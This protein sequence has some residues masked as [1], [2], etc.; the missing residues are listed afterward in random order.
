MF[1]PFM[2]CLDNVKFC[3][4]KDLIVAKDSV[5]SGYP[6][7]VQR[8]SLLVW[9]QFKIY[10]F[11]WS[12]YLALSD[13]GLPTGWSY[14]HSFLQQLLMGGHQTAQVSNT[15]NIYHFNLID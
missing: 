3:F 13:W 7:H 1:H 8:V 2:H 14:S 9:E 6:H 4:A 11:L 15:G 10:P 12:G 5:A